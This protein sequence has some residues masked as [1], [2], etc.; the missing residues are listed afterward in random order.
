MARKAARTKTA[1]RTARYRAR[2][3]ERHVPEAAAV[4]AALLAALSTEALAVAER[5]VSRESSDGDRACGELI[6]RIMSSASDHLVASGFD[7]GA[8][9][10]R[11]KRRLQ[12]PPRRR[13]SVHI[14]AQ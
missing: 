10:L 11:I 6:V 3:A 5:A 1:E 9:S 8:S 14:A 13:E 7:A 4:D 12:M 2:L